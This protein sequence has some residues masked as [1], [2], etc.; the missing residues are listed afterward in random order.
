MS[1]ES[2]KG[3]GRYYTRSR[4]RGGRV[5]RE[6]FGTGEVAELAAQMDGLRRRERIEAI[7]ARR[8]RDCEADALDACVAAACHAIDLMARAALVAAGFHQHHR[9]EW[10][11]R[12][13]KPDSAT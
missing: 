4:R 6:Y 2:R 3:R 7:E 8:R 13:G 11:R 1:W 12:R 9:G 10:R 5:I